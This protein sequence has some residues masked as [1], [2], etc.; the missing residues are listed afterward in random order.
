MVKLVYWLARYKAMSPKGRLQQKQTRHANTIKMSVK[1]LATLHDVRR[2]SYV[3][4]HKDLLLLLLLILLLWWRCWDFFRLLRTSSF[5]FVLVSFSSWRRVLFSS[6]RWAWCRWWSSCNIMQCCTISVVRGW[7]WSGIGWW[8][9]GIIHVSH[10]SLCCQ[11]RRVMICV[12]CW[13][14]FAEMLT[15]YAQNNV[16]GWVKNRALDSYP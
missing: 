12:L 13:P 5:V 10:F 16:P 2:R 6:R 3:V 4:H 9:F 14:E 1:H 11:H 7:C 8:T 15:W